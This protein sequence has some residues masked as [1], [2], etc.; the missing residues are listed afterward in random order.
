MIEAGQ[1]KGYAVNADKISEFAP[2]IAPLSDTPRMSNLHLETWYGVFAPV[3]LPSEIAITLQN[4]LQTIIENPELA[5][6]L[7]GQA[8]SISRKPA[9]ELPDFLA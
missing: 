8:I 9:K 5:K 2:A 6:S 7:A 3:K 1:V 4:K